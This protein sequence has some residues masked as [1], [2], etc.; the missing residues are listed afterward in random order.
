MDLLIDFT[1][2]VDLFYRRSIEK[3]FINIISRLCDYM[4]Y[5]DKKIN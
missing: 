1:K 3:K 2:I 5:V 4:N